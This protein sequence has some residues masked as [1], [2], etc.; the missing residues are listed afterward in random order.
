MLASITDALSS[1]FGYLVADGMSCLEVAPL[2][3]HNGNSVILGTWTK[4]LYV[5]RG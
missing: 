2:V 4:S 3:W 1:L 5:D